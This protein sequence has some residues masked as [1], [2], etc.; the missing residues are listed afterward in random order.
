[1]IRVTLIFSDLADFSARKSTK[2]EVL[3][4]VDLANVVM[5]KLIKHKVLL[6][7]FAFFSTVVWNEKHRSRTGTEDHDCERR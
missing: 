6:L 7:K 4:V 3:K 2:T 5:F 1:M